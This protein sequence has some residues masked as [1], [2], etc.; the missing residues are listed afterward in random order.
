MSAIISRS[1]IFKGSYQDLFQPEIDLDFQ[2]ITDSNA[3]ELPF[4]LV[5]IRVADQDSGTYCLTKSKI[6]VRKKTK[7]FI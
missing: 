6:K 2:E 3:I 4:H 1:E 7:I 5:F